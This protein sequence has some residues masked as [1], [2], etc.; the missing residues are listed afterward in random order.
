M[1]RILAINP[2]ST[3]TKIAVYDDDDLVFEEV[4]RYRPEEL[5][6]F[7][8]VMGQYR[9]RIEDIF[10]IL[11]RRGCQVSDFTAIIGRGGL[12]K[13]IESGVYEVNAKMISDLI[14]TGKIPHACNLGA[15]MAKE[16]ADIISVP[17]FIADPPVVDEF[18]PLAPA[19][20]APYT[21]LLPATSLSAW[22]KTPPTSGMRFDMYSGISF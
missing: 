6:V 2:G 7:E 13:P 16:I 14:G 8:T 10:E 4:I 22:R 9:K 18:C 15:P 5:T 1:H 21:M 19:H 20:A 17:A 11:T 3:S 12:L